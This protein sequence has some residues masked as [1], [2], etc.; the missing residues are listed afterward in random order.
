LW[1]GRVFTS[2]E[3][4]TMKVSLPL[5]AILRLIMVLMA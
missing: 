4:Q 5:K 1:M 3:T 2:P